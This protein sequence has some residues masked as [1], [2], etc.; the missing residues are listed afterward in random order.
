MILSGRYGFHGDEL[1]MLD[2]ARHLQASY[3]DQGVFAPLMARVSL[4]LFGVS[5]PGL[6]LWPALATGTTVVIGGLTA[7]EFGGR[8]RAQLLAAI[9]V[10]TMP[11][12]LGSGHVANT[13]SYMILACAALALVV[14]R[15]GRT[16]DTRWWL[17]GGVI[18]GLGADDNHLVGILAV[19]VTICAL[20]CGGRPMVLDRWFLAGAV[21]A[22][23]FLVPDLWWQADHDWATI[24]MTHA[25]NHKNGGVLGVISWVVGQLLIASL[26]MVLLWVAGLRFLWRSGRPLW[27]ALFGA[28]GLLFVVFALTT[29]KQFYYLAGLY[30]CLLAAGAVS[31][32]GWLHERPA[33]LR[34]LL[35]ATAILAAG[36]MLTTLPVLPPGDVGW[37]ANINNVQSSTVGW[38]QLVSTVRTVWRSLP[39]AQRS[40]AVVF[41]ASYS[42]AG[43]INELGRGT[44]LPNAVSGHNTDWWWGPGNPNATS[45]VVIAPGIK[46]AADYGT[47]LGRFCAS[48]REAA[49]V[50]NPYG[51]HNDE[52]GGHVYVCT[53]LRQPLG[54]IWPQLRHYD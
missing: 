9:A 15:V 45:M 7:R 3:V 19:A 42:E 49:T 16:G 28:Y 47:Y 36:S 39:P 10:A 43:A 37:T 14:A 52:W 18:A 48:V 38:P 1:Y 46:A 20:L 13:T 35:A 40:S 24:A 50:S 32:D 4:S 2:C 8:R 30:V 22:A 44:G 41:T 25:L 33:R 23:A 34:R 6:R 11:T 31:L 29:G 26:A 21:L 5:A 17:A 27:R 54:Q 53:G 51:V 12:L